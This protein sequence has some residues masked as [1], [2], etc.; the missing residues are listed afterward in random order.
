MNS[1]DLIN[2]EALKLSGLTDADRDFLQHL[3]ADAA[4]GA[5][6]FD[7]LR[8]VKGPGALPLRGGPITPAVA[9]SVLYRIAHDIADRVGIQQGY[10]LAPSVGATGVEPGGD[11]L[12]LT[13][14]AE[15]IG[16]S[17]P[18]THQALVEGRLR[19]H[20]VGNAWIVRRADAEAFGASRSNRGGIAP[21]TDATGGARAARVTAFR[22]KVGAI[23][24]WGR[25]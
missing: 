18:A 19:G 9:R 14:A 1:Y 8:R 12:S 3:S 2:G 20:R 22:G 13:E 6:Y 21:S 7:L 10:L 25:R 23:T 15:L 17:R 24:T 4:G 5:D 16:I 11:L